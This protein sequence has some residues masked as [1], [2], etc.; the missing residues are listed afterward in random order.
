VVFDDTN[1]MSIRELAS[2]EEMYY[3]YSYGRVTG[4]Y[5]EESEAI[6]VAYD[7]SGVVM[8]DA[9]K[10]LWKRISRSYPRRYLDLSPPATPIP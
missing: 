8:D 3:V 2:S 5:T 6:R 9:G 7:Q 10:Y 1:A 4:V